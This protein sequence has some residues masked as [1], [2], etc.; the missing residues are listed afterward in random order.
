MFVTGEETAIDGIN[1]NDDVAA[2]ALKIP[3]LE[4][5]T[6]I[7]GHLPFM[8]RLVSF[9]VTGK[10]EPVIVS[11]KPGSVV[12]LAQNAERQWHISWML[13]PDCV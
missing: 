1:P 10:E 12:C 11:F 6:L 4:A 13:R 7:V 9:L 3:K 2:F 5:D 8:A